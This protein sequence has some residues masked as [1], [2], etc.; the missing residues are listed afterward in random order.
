MMHGMEIEDW[1]IDAPSFYW[2]YLE[3]HENEKIS[4]YKYWLR[5]LGLHDTASILFM[6]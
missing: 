1:V 5:S 4:V 6:L 3:G 2:L